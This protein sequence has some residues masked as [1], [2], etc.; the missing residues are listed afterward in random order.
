[1]SEKIGKGKVVGFS[2]TLKNDSGEVLDK[3]SEPLVYLHGG[4]N[5]IEG[6]ESG[7]EGLSVGDSRKIDVAA[8]EA[9]GEYDAQLLQK[10]EKE[11]FPTDTPIEI[12]M[13]FQ[14]RSDEGVMVFHVKEVHLD[15]IIMDGNHPLAGE[16]LHFDVNIASIRDATGEEKQHGHAH[17]AGGHHHH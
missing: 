5:I 15:H 4:G 17:G 13:Q 7:L 6:L 14:A 8:R 1:M 16:N 12:G 2:Y 11:A 10:V 3:S 9:Y